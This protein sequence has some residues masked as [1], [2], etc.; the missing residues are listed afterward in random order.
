MVEPVSNVRIVLTTAGS[1]QDAERLARTLVEEHLAACATLIP[2]AHS[3]YRWKGKIESDHESLM[4][5]KTTAEQIDALEARLHQLHTYQTPEF[6]V[7]EVTAGSKR[8]LSWLQ[9]ACTC[10]DAQSA[11]SCE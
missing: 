6:L 4:M 9:S 11:L 8:Y 1:P 10:S 2:A 5:L 3:I 7:L